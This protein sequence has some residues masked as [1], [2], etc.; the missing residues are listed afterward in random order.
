MARAITSPRILQ[1]FT[2]RALP[3]HHPPPVRWRMI[4]Q[5]RQPDWSST[6]LGVWYSI[7]RR[8]IGKSNVTGMRPD[9][10]LRRVIGSGL[11]ATLLLE[12]QAAG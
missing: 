6:R 1:G 10:Y 9:R 2:L 4:K 3:D 7:H 11:L 5:G 8:S 12:A